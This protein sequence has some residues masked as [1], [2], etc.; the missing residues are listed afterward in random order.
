MVIRGLHADEGFALMAWALSALFMLRV[1]A[2]AIQR[3]APQPLLPPFHEFQGSSIPYWMLLPVQL[4]IAAV[5]VRCSWRMQKRTLTAG[6]KTATVL[7]AGGSIYM[8]GSI[9]RLMIGL[10]APS[11]PAWFTAWIPAA[12]H[13]VLAAFVLELGVYHRVMARAPIQKQP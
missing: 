8:A 11:P 12:F 6:K 5:M 10:I 9:A 2:Q 7:L 4:L 13:L 3:W 1:C